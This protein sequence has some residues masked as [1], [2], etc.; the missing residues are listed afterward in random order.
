M[1]VVGKITGFYFTNTKYVNNV[2]T[3]FKGNYRITET[4][5]LTHT[6]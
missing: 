4:L 5:P 1:E 2:D 3:T 6:P